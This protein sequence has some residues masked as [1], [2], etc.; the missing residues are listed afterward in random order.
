MTKW[1]DPKETVIIF[2]WDDTLF[3][4][5]A[6]LDDP[7]MNWRELCDCYGGDPGMALDPEGAPDGSLREALEQHAKTVAAVLRLSASLG[8]V[9]IVTLAAAGW[10]E[11]SVKNYMPSLVGLLPEILP[12]VSYARHALKTRELE[13]AD[14]DG[15]DTCLVMKTRAFAKVLRDFHGESGGGSHRSWKNIISIG[16]SKTEADALQELA[17]EKVQVDRRG[18]EKAFR[19][20]VLKLI[21]V[22]TILELTS[23]L[24]VLLSWLNE[25]IQHDGDFILDFDEDED[26][27]LCAREFLSAQGPILGEE[28]DKE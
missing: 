15:L 18:R 5:T 20:K 3:P 13:Q 19:C 4:S 10:V 23:Q 24:Q 1:S 6:I 8:R 14:N 16:D 26:A 12:P 2:D 21:E 27:M 25:A 11:L 28:V 17:M 7:R 22:P 9:A